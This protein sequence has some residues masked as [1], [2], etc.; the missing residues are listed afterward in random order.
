MEILYLHGKRQK[1]VLYEICINL[2]Y[3]LLYLMNIYLMDQD[4]EHCSILYSILFSIQYP[5]FLATQFSKI[6]NNLGFFYSRG[7]QLLN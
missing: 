6:A 1:F 3:M 7:K 4:E 5:V 2:H